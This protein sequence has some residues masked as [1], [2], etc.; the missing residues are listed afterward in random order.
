MTTGQSSDRNSLSSCATCFGILSIFFMF[1][2]LFTILMLA[3]VSTCNSNQFV[4]LPGAPSEPV[5]DDLPKFIGKFQAAKTRAESRAISSHEIIRDRQWN[6]E[7]RRGRKMYDEARAG[8][9]EC[10]SFIQTALQRRFENRDASDIET[11]LDSSEAS[12]SR[13]MAWCDS[14]ER[15]AIGDLPVPDVAK[16]LNDWLARNDQANAEAIRAVTEKLETCRWRP[17]DDITRSDSRGGG[18]L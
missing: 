6:A 13:F 9:D 14:L 2:S 7:M 11:L 8:F 10:I 1:L 16:F 15:P 12:M 5:V 18:T 4:R 3:F 17:W